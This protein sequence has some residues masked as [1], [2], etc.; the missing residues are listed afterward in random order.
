MARP[1]VD[2]DFLDGTHA[3]ELDA[4]TVS[5]LWDH[6]DESDGDFA[7]PE[8]TGETLHFFKAVN[9]IRPVHLVVDGVRINRFLNFCNDCFPGNASIAD[10]QIVRNRR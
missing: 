1:S 3:G 5:E 6:V 8:L 7:S 10:W 2:I 4:E 9:G